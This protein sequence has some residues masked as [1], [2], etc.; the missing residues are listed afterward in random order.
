MPAR[1]HRAEFT[2][3]VANPSMASLAAAVQLVATVFTTLVSSSELNVELNVW[4]AAKLSTYCVI[5]LYC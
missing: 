1:L 3:C 4:L 5:C 2:E